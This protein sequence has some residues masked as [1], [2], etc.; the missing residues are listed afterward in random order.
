V[1][2]IRPELEKYGSKDCQNLS[3][4]LWLSPQHQ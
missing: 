2:L 4:K 3:F 1:I